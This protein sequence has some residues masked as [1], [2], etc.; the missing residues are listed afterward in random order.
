MVEILAYSFHTFNTKMHVYPL[1]SFVRMP[2]RKWFNLGFSYKNVPLL[3]RQDKINIQA[4]YSALD[5]IICGANPP[6]H[7]AHNRTH[8]VYLSYWPYWPDYPTCTSLPASTAKRI[9]EQTDSLQIT[10]LSLAG[11]RI[12]WNSLFLG[13][14]AQG[15]I[16]TVTPCAQWEQR[17]EWCKE[18]FTREH[19]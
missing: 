2:P 19:G 6:P 3:G 4:H 15:M 12:W 13:N 9:H 11:P 8:S 14:E 5:C 7:N 17:W 16:L 18:A 10:Q 1:N